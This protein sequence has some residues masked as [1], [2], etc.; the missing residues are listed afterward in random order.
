[1]STTFLILVLML[2]PFQVSPSHSVL[3]VKGIL[4]MQFCI[5]VA[6]QKLVFK[7]KT[8]TGKY[9]FTFAW[10][11]LIKAS[12]NKVYTFGSPGLYKQKGQNN[13]LEQKYNDK[14][15]WPIIR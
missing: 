11:L 1:M 10:S 15:V 7:G 5:P 6:D 9:I 4:E 12:G 13:I 2:C 3:D 8:L 14:F